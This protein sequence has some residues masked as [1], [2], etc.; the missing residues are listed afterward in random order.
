MIAVALVSHN[1][2]CSLNDSE[3]DV[4]MSVPRETVSGLD[5]FVFGSDC[6]EKPPWYCCGYFFDRA[7]IIYAAR[8]AVLISLLTFS[9]VN[10]CYDPGCEETTLYFSVLSSLVTYFISDPSQQYKGPSS[11]GKSTHLI[12]RQKECKQRAVTTLTINEQANCQPFIS[13]Q[14]ATPCS[15]AE[16][17]PKTIRIDNSDQTSDCSYWRT[18]C[19]NI[20]RSAVFFCTQFGII[21]TILG[22]CLYKLSWNPRCEDKAIYFPILTGLTAY[23]APTPL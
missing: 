3:K 19:C 6:D 21:F 11:T 8:A 16:R 18:S 9:L 10:L 13:G 2:N 12:Q 4:S 15:S 14:E 20:S 23:L 5:S 7:L 22:F 17:D 1:K